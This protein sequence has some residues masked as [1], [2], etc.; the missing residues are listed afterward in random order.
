MFILSLGACSSRHDAGEKYYL[1]SANIKNAYWQAA[2]AGFVQ[3]A[4]G[5]GVAAEVVGPE[6]YD[7]QAE[8]Q[9]FRDAAAKLPAGIL[10]SVT[11]PNLL[12][13]PIDSAIAQKILVITID[14]DAP[15]SKR[16]TFIGTNN[17]QAGLAGGRVLAERLHGKG[18]V[19]FYTMPGQPNLDE[20]LQGYKTIL[21]DRAQMKIVQ[22]VDVKGDAGIAF[23][24]T[25]EMLHRKPAPDAFVCLVSFACPEVAEVLDRNKV[26]GK[27][28][29]AMDTDPNTL[30]WIQ[31][32]MIDATIAQ[33]P[34]TMSHYGVLML[35]SMHH[36]KLPLL[37]IKWSEDTRSPMPM[38]VDTGAI[39]IDKSNIEGFLKAQTV[40]NGS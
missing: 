35:D 2:G 25:K 33:K 16:L 17:Y 26:S 31:K 19:V 40:E 12:K 9:A 36:S 7:P 24:S 21:G 10:V 4:R 32:G 39:L 28:V 38:F 6:K 29:V 14:S 5:L 18:N 23:D 3:A 15:A 22:V 8:A 30:T 20:R 27:V 34:F 37:D 1:V 13:E 11:D